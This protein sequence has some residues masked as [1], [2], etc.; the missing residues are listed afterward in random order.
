MNPHTDSLARFT[1]ELG[2]IR[3]LSAPEQLRR[4][5]RDFFW[6][7]PI[8]N[9]QLE[10]RTADLVVVPQTEDEV[11]TIARAAARHGLP[12]TVRGGGTGNYGQCVPLAGGVVLDMTAMNRI[13]SIR[14]GVAEVQA[15]VLLHALQQEAEKV[16]QQLRMFPSTLR[17]A[18]VGGFIAGGSAGV[19]SVRNGVLKDPGN[20][21]SVQVVTLEETP[22]VLELQ[23]ED[24][25]KV[26]HA[27]GTNGIITR[28]TLALQAAVHWY[29]SIATFGSYAD[30]TRFCHGICGTDIDLFLLTAVESGFTPYYKHLAEYFPPGSHAVFAMVGEDSRERYRAQARAFGGQE[31]LCL[32]EAELHARRLPPAYECAYNHTTLQALKADKSWTYLQFEHPHPFDLDL[33]TRFKQR[34]GDEVL[35]HDEFLRAT[36]TE[37]GAYGLPLVRFTTAARQYE[38]MDFLEASG[39]L[40]FDPHVYTIEDGGMKTIDQNQLAFKRLADPA[41]LMNPGKMKAWEAQRAPA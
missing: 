12:V 2:G 30:A 7:S 37:Y 17:A 29:H 15:G 3:V 35:C 10:G 14:D 22:R 36:P 26:H 39:C 13:L 19:G 38:I 32:P 28:V 9:E 27:Y 1:E 25:Q 11:V 5:S 23:G 18:T 16:G 40:I 34:F 6:Y 31:T 4:K 24:V 8:L 20:V 41:G 21:L 33:C